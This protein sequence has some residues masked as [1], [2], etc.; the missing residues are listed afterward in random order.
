MTGDATPAGARGFWPLRDLPVVAWLLA[1]VV[2][3]VAHPLVPAPRWLLIHL[4]L[5]GAVSHA[6]LVWS[7]HFADAL[8][9]VPTRP[10]DRRVQSRRLVLLDGGAV[11][12]VA[13]VSADLWP[14]TVAGATAVSAA[15]MNSRSTGRP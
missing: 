13:G 11:A 6:I 3:A 14:L 1:V 4:L 12:V 8:L 9:H 2:V 5:L 15:V 7:R 10:G